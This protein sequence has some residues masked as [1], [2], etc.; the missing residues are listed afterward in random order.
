[1]SINGNAVCTGLVVP[2]VC[3]LALK[4]KQPAK[5]IVIDSLS[6]LMIMFNLGVRNKCCNSIS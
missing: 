4:H 6:L 5:T 1:M 3:A 2:E